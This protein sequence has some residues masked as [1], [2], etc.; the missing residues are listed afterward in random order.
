[1]KTKWYSTKRYE[2]EALVLG[3]ILFIGSWVLST[4]FGAPEL[5][6]LPLFIIGIVLTILSAFLITLRLIAPYF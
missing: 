5:I 3:V 6:R 4:Q 2:F 1:M